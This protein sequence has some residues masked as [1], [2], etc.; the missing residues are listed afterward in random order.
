[1]ILLQPIYC[2]GHPENYLFQLIINNTICRIKASKKTFNFE[3]KMT[4]RK[5]STRL[6]LNSHHW[7]TH[8]NQHDASV[9]TKHPFSQLVDQF[10]S[11]ALCRSVYQACWR[12]KRLTKPY[13]DINTK[14]VDLR[15]HERD[16]HHMICHQLCTYYC[17]P[18][19]W[20]WTGLEVAYFM[21]SFR[22]PVA[23]INLRIRYLQ[24]D[25]VSTSFVEKSHSFTIRS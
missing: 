25:K 17:L 11:F 4:D 1:M 24:F 5:H 23:R 18:K 2:S 13:V 10:S 21:V 16:I 22:Q 7:T 20:K 19:E 6:D 12:R 14:A 15:I 3:N 8:A 9:D